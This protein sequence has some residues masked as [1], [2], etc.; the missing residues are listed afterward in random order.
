MHDDVVRL[1]DQHLQQLEAVRRTLCASRQVAWGERHTAL[2]ESVA[3]SRHYT[4]TAL[5]LLAQV[6]DAAPVHST[7]G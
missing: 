2:A 7:G 5:G 4:A 6:G 1:L 3:A